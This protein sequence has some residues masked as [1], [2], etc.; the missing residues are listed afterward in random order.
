VR[1]RV[2]NVSV[3]VTRTEPAA[4]GEWSRPTAASTRIRGRASDSEQRRE[5]SNQA[6][7]AGIH[8]TRH[9]FLET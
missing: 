3:E 6:A 8:A 5:Y 1:Q 9:G 2:L 7:A 4:A